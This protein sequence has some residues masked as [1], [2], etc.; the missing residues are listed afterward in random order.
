[1]PEAKPQIRRPTKTLEQ[2]TR[3][4]RYL[5]LWKRNLC[6]KHYVP[7]KMILLAMSGFL[8]ALGHHLYWNSLSGTEITQSAQRW[9]NVFGMALAFLVK[10]ALVGAVQVCMQATILGSYFFCDGYRAPRLIAPAA[11][12]QGEIAPAQNN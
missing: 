8:T 10:T 2:Q 7:I 12:C 3:S 9:Q 5:D 6:T 4:I 1:M 11:R